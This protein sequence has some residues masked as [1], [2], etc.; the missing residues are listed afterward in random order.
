MAGTPEG[1]LGAVLARRRGEL[2]LTQLQ[3][4]K[5]TGHDRTHISDLERGKKNMSVVTLIGLARALRITPSALLRE[6]ER[7]FAA[8]EAAET[9]EAVF[10]VPPEPPGG[11]NGGG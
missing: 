5:L 8:F 10:G 11:E 6:A 3:V 1:H 2:G 9:F 7:R 4:A